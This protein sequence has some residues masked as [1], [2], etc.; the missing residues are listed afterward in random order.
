[1]SSLAENLRDLPALL[2]GHLLLSLCA[3]ATAAA[4]TL[5]LAVAADRSEKV[6]RISL[7]LAGTMLTIPSL[8]LLAIMVPL[9]GGTIGFAPA[10]AALTLYAVLPM[11]Q[12][13]IAGLDAVDPSL[14]EA[15]RGL[16]MSERQILRRVRFP[17][18]LP[19]I[20]AGLRTAAV[21]T[22]GTATLA[23]AVGASGLGT[24]IFTGLQTRN[25]GMM[26]F[27]CFFAA[28]LAIV[29]DQALSLVE[30]ALQTRRQGTARL[31]AAVSRRGWLPPSLGVAALLAA[32]AAVA[33]LFQ[34]ERKP[35]AA[36]VPSPAAASPAAAQKPLAGLTLTT[37]SKPFIESYIHAELLALEL[38]NAGAS[39]DNRPNM[40]STILFD[41]LRGN[42]VDCYVDYSGTIWATIMKRD[43]PASRL[44]TLIETAGYLLREH[45][46]AAIGPLG[47]RNDYCFAMRRGRAAMLG[48]RSIADMAGRNL[49]I[50]GDPEVFGRPEWRRV[51]EAYALESLTTVGMQKIYMFEA[52][53]NDQVDAIVAYTTDGRIALHDLALLDDPEQVLPPYDAMLLVSPEASA[54]AALI[55]VLSNLVNRIDGALM[56]GANRAVDVDGQTPEAAAAALWNRLRSPAPPSVSGG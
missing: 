40:G 18:A 14:I 26:L 43:E 10:Y 2:S 47:Y 34:S 55:D 24:Y 1:M 12:N 16:G 13:T 17:L 42:T 19:V 32:A 8:A 50:A 3:L 31:A 41:A 30:R 33:P 28:A 15:A 11:L 46:V 54:N 51:R 49:R 21:W 45:G 52:V 20:L 22:V 53:M 6:K 5:I 39:V 37:G 9:L 7:N 29:L 25:H 48:I 44:E 27:G 38:E 36:S 23:T 4:L 56:R 35:T